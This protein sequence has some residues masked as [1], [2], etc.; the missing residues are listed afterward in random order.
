VGIEYQS[1]LLVSC[2]LGFA[3]EVHMLKHDAKDSWKARAP[4][5]CANSVVLQCDWK[6]TACDY[7]ENKT[8][9]R[10]LV[11]QDALEPRRMP[12]VSSDGGLSPTLITVHAGAESAVVFCLAP[13][14]A[15]SPGGPVPSWCSGQE[16]RI[17]TWQ[18]NVLARTSFLTM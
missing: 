2:A 4:I 13:G 3:A 14:C 16:P 15:Y 1:R 10:R 5:C 8:P 11:K 6:H 18:A 17:Q 7:A 12:T 9:C